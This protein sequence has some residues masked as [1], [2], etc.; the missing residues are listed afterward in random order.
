M[1]AHVAEQPA[2]ACLKRQARKRDKM[3]LIAVLFLKLSAIF[4]QAIYQLFMRDD[5]RD[6]IVFDACLLRETA[7]VRRA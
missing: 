4:A 6:S 7:S 3:F 5:S 1:L 2:T